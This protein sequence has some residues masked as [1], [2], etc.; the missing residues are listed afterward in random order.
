[1]ENP[2]QPILDVPARA[3]DLAELS[4]HDAPTRE[5]AI[6]VA[7]AAAISRLLASF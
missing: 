4:D 7:A 6:S 1:M 3:N 2:L 5:Q